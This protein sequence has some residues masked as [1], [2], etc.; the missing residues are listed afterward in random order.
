MSND[1]KPCKDKCKLVGDD[2]KTVQNEIMNVRSSEI[3]PKSNNDMKCAPTKQFKD[4]SCISLTTLVQMANAYNIEYSKDPI[5][6]STKLEVLNPSKYKK[7][8][9]KQF[10]KK[11]KS[12]EDQK[13]WS[14]Q[15]FIKHLD[16]NVKDE[17]TKNTFRPKGPQG[18]FTWLN[19][20]N[21][22]HVFDQYMAKHNDFKFFGAVP[23]DFDDLDYYELR[24]LDFSKLVDEG[25]TK[26]GVV[27][28]LDKHN[29]PGSHWV[30]LYADLDAGTVYFSDS[31][32][33]KPDKRIANF[34]RRI[35]KFI[36]GDTE[37]KAVVEYNN[38]RHQFG[39]SECG[40]YSISFILRLLRGDS[41]ENITENV[42][43]DDTINKC[44]NYYF[45]K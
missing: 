17:L 24:G 43:D 10:N 25:K 36:E 18:Q 16:G 32:G 15:S 11:L 39:N 45:A 13:C 22:N 12:C 2:D 14:K 40:V 31:Y 28:N 1:N 34:M 9:V 5:R 41:F 35:A 26:I 30:G 20:L 27:F 7:Y 29:Q 19:T 6:L 23:I 4:G 3:I 44:R 21:I 8:L 37:K 42:V 38:V 33:I